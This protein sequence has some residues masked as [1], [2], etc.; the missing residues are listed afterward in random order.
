M[1]GGP[2]MASDRE[3]KWELQDS[4]SSISPDC[5]NKEGTSRDPESSQ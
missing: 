4:A 1:V 3:I 5:A 2:D